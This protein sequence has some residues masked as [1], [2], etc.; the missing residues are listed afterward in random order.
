[1]VIIEIAAQ[2][3]NLASKSIDERVTFVP[4]TALTLTLTVASGTAGLVGAP[5]RL[6]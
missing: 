3:A 1:M 6:A 5:G 2:V 4:A